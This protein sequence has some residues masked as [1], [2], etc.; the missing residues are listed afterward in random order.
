MQEEFMP[1]ESKILTAYRVIIST[2]L[3]KQALK[4]EDNKKLYFISK[5]LLDENFA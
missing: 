2:S 5:S 3:E 4:K 1:S